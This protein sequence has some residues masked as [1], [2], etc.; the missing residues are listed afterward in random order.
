LSNRKN[1]GSRRRA[2]DEA[3]AKEDW[4]LAA[5]LS[6]GLRASTKSKS[7]PRRMPKEWTQS[8]LDRFI[9]E[10]D[11]DAVAN[12]IAHVRDSA[13]ASTQRS[14]AAAPASSQRKLIGPANPKKRFG[15]LS[16][17]QHGDINSDSSWD[18]DASSYYSDDY[19]S[20]SS[21]TDEDD[22]LYMAAN[23]KRRGAKKE[24]TC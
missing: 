12:Y 14:S 1:N 6:E 23:S 5:D 18:S 17:L 2:L 8:E 21:Y 11:W 4:D 22:P 10:N 19:S 7:A 15:A 3:I 9:S 13:K 16:Q 20:A 24:F